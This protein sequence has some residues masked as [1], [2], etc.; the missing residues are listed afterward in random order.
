MQVL[1]VDDEPLARRRLV[2]LISELDGFKL[3]GEAADGEA[4]VRMAQA[5]EADIVLLDVRMPSMDGMDAAAA[6]NRLAQPPV[7]IFCTAFEEH[8]L[9]AFQVHAAD[10]L[11]KPIR[12]ERLRVA[13]DKARHLRLAARGPLVAASQQARTHICAHVR[14][15]EVLVPVGQVSHLQAEDR[16]VRVHHSQ[17]EVLIEDSLRALEADFPQR[18]VRIHRNCLVSRDHIHAL[19]RQPDGTLRLRLADQHTMLDVSRRNASALRRLL[20][21]L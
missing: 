10:Y 4:A 13:L 17:G 14:G 1:V 16:Y 18:F 7:I 19:E 15:D 8:A 20:R 11:I 12:R 5:S 9:D 2:S 6:L 3:A 21:H